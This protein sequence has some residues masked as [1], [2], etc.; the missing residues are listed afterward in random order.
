MLSSPHGWNFHAQG[1]FAGEIVGAA[2][3]TRDEAERLARRLALALDP[4][5]SY[6]VR[7]EDA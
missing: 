2:A 4:C 7:V 1:A 6:E 3:T 5:V